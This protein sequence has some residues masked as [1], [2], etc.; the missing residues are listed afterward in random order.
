MRGRGTTGTFNTPADEP[1]VAASQPSWSSAR[2]GWGPRHGVS[3]S[4]ASAGVSPPQELAVADFSPKSEAMGFPWGRWDEGWWVKVKDTV[5]R[6]GY[7]KPDAVPSSGK[8]PVSLCWSRDSSSL[9]TTPRVQTRSP[10]PAWQGR[11][12]A[13]AKPLEVVGVSA[14][15][16]ERRTLPNCRQNLSHSPP[17]AAA[18]E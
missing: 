11:E 15:R 17:N 4:P 14:P 10:V 8:V 3:L 6:P 12:G 2:R 7:S 5:D 13:G 16:R 18:R 1:W 9:V